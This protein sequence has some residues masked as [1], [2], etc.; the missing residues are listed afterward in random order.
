MGRSGVLQR[1]SFH[2]TVRLVLAY[3]PNCPRVELSGY[4]VPVPY[5]QCRVNNQLCDISKPGINAV[6]YERLTSIFFTH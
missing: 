4:Q 5:S 2:N 1:P 3:G 6:I